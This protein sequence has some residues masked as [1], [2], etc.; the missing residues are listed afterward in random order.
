[1]AQLRAIIQLQQHTIVT[2]KVSTGIEQVCLAG[3]LTTPYSELDFTRTQNEG[4]QTTENQLGTIGNKIIE[5]ELTIQR[6]R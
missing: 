4:L 2:G 3:S 6:Q 1:M 5:T